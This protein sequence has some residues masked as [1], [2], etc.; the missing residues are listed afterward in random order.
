[1]GTARHSPCPLGGGGLL[2]QLDLVG[3]VCLWDLELSSSGA[4]AVVSCVR[5]SPPGTCRV[6]SES[7]EGS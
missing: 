3:P 2:R 7:K 1:M 5:P 4:F 6:L